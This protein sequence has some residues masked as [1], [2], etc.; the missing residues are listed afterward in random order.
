[1]SDQTSDRRGRHTFWIDDR[2]LDD[3]A[4]IFGR[5]SFG[6][7]VIAVYAALARRAD[8]DGDSW[9]RLRSIATQA[10][11][12]PR[13]AQRAIRLLEL[14]GLVEVAARYERGSNRQTSNLYTLLTPPERP[15]AVDDDP[16]AWPAPQRRI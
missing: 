1:M 3:Y 5:F 13:T 12:S 15:P 7:A 8:R 4:P 6:P 14:L 11:T 16:D 9:P 10:A 2:L